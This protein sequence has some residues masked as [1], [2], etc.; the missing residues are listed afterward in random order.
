MI[1]SPSILSADFSKLYEDTL[2]VNKASWLHIDVMDGI[3]VPNIS[4]GAP[5]QKSIRA[6]FNQVFDTHLMI[7]DPLKYIDDF[8][9]AGSDYI[10]FHIEAKSDINET[11]NK[12]HSLN[13]KAGLSIKP[14]TEPNKLIPYLDKIDL[15]LV[16]SV[17]PGFGGQKYMPHAADKIK[18]LDE[19]R[20]N[21]NLNYLISVDGGINDETKE[22]VKEAGVDVVVMGSYL[23]KQEKPNEI[24]EKIEK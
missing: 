21:N 14:N 2:R 1:V 3:F 8:A 6:K 9:K 12:I 15:V 11:I 10:T 23:F 17:E 13:I 19:Y 16:M 22:Y 24:I 18:W 4:F 20:K 5:I 7:T